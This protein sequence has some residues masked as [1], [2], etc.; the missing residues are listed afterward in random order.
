[1]TR[2]IG[3]ARAPGCNPRMGELTERLRAAPSYPYERWRRRA[4]ATP[5]S[6]WETRQALPEAPV[7]RRRRRQLRGGAG[8]GLRPAR[9]E[10]RRQDDDDRRAHHAG[11]ADRRA[12]PRWPASTSPRDPVRAPQRRLAVVPQR[13]NLDRSLSIR[14]NLLF[15]AALPRR[16]GGTSAP[17]APTSCSSSSA[18]PTGPT[19]RSTSFS[20]GQAQ[21]I[22]IARALMHAPEVLFLDEPTTG[23]DPPARLFVWDRIRDLSERGVTIVIL[24]THDMDEAA[25]LADRVGHHGP[26]QAAR[27]RH[28]RTR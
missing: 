21:R 19:T 12:R 27:P 18:S 1:M 17:A 24:T 26:R 23:L 3:A 5:R 10:R 13:S 25:T 22:M 15:H 2:M 7:E 14:Q 28:A 4:R 16:P 6:R 20:G 9:P 11:Q 8:R